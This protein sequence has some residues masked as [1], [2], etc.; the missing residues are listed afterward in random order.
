MSKKELLE[1]IVHE[2]K[3]TGCRICQLICSSIYEKKY[4]PT[5]AFIQIQ[6]YYQLSPTI[7]FSENCTKCGQCVSHCLYGALE[8][9]EGVT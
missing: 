4:A 7:S 6:D 1:I 9:N 2:D 5:R 8:V 3:C